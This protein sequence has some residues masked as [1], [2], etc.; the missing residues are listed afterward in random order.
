MFGCFIVGG[1]EK[2]REKKKGER[3]FYIKRII[4]R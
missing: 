4:K 3:L 1:R 2:K